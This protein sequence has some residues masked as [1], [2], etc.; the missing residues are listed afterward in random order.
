MK[1]PAA[2]APRRKPTQTVRRKASPDAVT[3]SGETVPEGSSDD[4][5]AR[6]AVI[7]YELY[8]QRGGHDGHDLAD[9]LAAERR[10]VTDGSSGEER[11]G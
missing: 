5:R 6:I 8:R 9:W 2:S 7:A 11:A 10:V 3:I 1:L 4:V